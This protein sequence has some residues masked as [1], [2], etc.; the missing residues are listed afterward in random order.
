M[1]IKA[2]TDVR[3]APGHSE[4]P[5]GKRLR[6]RDRRVGQGASC[7]PTARNSRSSPRSCSHSRLSLPPR[8]HRRGFL[9]CRGTIRARSPISGWRLTSTTFVPESNKRLLRTHTNELMVERQVE[10]I[11][12]PALT[13]PA[14]P[15]A[16]T[17]DNRWLTYNDPDGRFHFRHPQE[18]LPN[19]QA[20]AEDEN[21]D[22]VIL[23][24]SPGG[25][26]PGK[27]DPARAHPQNRQCRGRP[28]Q[29]RPQLLRQ[30][31]QGDLGRSPHRSDPGPDGL[32]SRGGLAALQHEGLPDRGRTQG[33]RSGGPRMSH[34]S[35]T[36]DT[37]SCSPGTSAWSSPR[38]PPKIPRSPFARRSRRSSRASSSN[39]P[40]RRAERDRD[41]DDD[42]SA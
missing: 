38:R 32:A 21:T 13:V 11:G 41:R 34:G 40:R 28:Q 35:S 25:P 1:P 22:A 14:T 18:Y 9:R 29:S 2:G 20:A 7:L 42:P 33:G 16:P 6:G 36:I 8:G 30:A 12:T 26:D 15:P 10:P 5:Q 4:E 39:L 3:H 17:K 24:D 19:K 31:A 37:S 27:P 23:M